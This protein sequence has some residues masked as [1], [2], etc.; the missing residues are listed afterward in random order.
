MGPLVI[1]R[2]ATDQTGSLEVGGSHQYGLMGRA[3]GFNLPF[4]VQVGCR[5]AIQF[6]VSVANIVTCSVLTPS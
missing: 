2:L 3:R 5:V 4:P 6:W 1:P